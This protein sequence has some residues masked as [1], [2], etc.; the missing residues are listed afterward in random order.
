MRQFE[1]ETIWK[2][3]NQIIGSSDHFKNKLHQN[4]LFFF[5]PA[6]L[7]DQRRINWISRKKN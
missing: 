6:D 4:C 3:E 1:N 7:A 5:V 2:F